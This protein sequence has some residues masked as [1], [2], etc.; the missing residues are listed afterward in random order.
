M[1]SFRFGIST[2][3]VMVM[4]ASAQD[5]G[6]S[7]IGMV[8]TKTGLLV[9]SNDDNDFFTFEINGEK[10]NAFQKDGYNF[11]NVNNKT[12]Q[13]NIESFADFL[14]SKNKMPEL[15][16]LQAN[17]K[18]E[19]KNMEETM[20]TKLD[21]KIEN[22]KC[23]NGRLILVWSFKMPKQYTS[24]KMQ[25][26]VTTVTKNHVLV[27]NGVISKESNY[28]EIDRILENGMNSLKPREIA[29]NPYA[30]QDSI[31]NQK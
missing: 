29:I 14:S 22:K 26:Y 27:L 10:P 1:K 15:D 31:K 30:L 20:K 28:E 18:Y 25:L 12:I 3:F 23:K 11:I 16:I 19:L 24:T 2:L 17:L 13:F 21:V 7:P 4:L 5:N 8:Y 9:F 6:P